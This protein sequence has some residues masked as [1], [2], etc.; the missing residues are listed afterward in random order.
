MDFVGGE[1]GGGEG[2]DEG[3][4]AGDGFDFEA[5]LEGG[6][7]DALAGIADAGCAGVGDEGDFFAAGEALDD[8]FAALGFVEFE[9]AE[10]RFFD[11]VGLEK[12][13]GVAGIFGGDDVAFAEDAEGAEGD[14]LAVA[15]GSGDEVKRSGDER[16]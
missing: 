8:L 2:G 3:A 14:V 12:I 7:D 11:F 9:V 13:R 6:A 4:G 16:R 15:D 10:E 5:G 1:A